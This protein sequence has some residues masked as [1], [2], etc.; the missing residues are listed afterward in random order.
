FC[1]FAMWRSP[2]AANAAGAHK[3][4]Y[5]KLSVE[6]SFPYSA[7]ELYFIPELSFL[8]IILCVIFIFHY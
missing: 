4:C 7:T 8:P 5:R 1:C 6:R 3:V 2:E